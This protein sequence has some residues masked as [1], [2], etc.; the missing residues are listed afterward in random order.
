MEWFHLWKNRNT[1]NTTCNATELSKMTGKLVT[2]GY[3]MFDTSGTLLDPRDSH[4][5]RWPG[6]EILNVIWVNEQAEAL[7]YYEKKRP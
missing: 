2:S 7:K 1:P 5:A 6:G 3:R 4:T